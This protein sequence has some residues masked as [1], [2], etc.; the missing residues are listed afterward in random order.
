VASDHCNIV[1]NTKEGPMAKMCPL[2][3]CRSKRG[4]CVHDK[5]MLTMGTLMGVLA[6]AHWGLRWI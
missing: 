1:I 3:G 6:A 5:I 4:L 2:D